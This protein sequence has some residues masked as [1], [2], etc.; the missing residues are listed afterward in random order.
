MIAFKTRIT[1]PLAVAMSLL[2][3]AAA[4]GAA[5]ESC[6]VLPADVWGGIMGYTATA[7]PG[8]MYC[9]YK[10]KSGGGQ[11]RIMAVAESSAAAE[12]GA[13]RLRDMQPKDDPMASLG[14]FYSQGSVIFTIALFQDAPTASTATQLQKL[15]AAAKQRLPK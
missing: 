13:R 10:G 3:A 4:A 5:P 6:Q 14:G 8:E 2:A 9:T 11:L 1:P 12:A 7:T 15:V